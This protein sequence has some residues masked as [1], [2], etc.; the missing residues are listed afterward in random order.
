MNYDLNRFKI[1]QESCYDK[2]LQEIKTGKKISHWMWFIFPQIA[3]LGKTDIAKKYEIANI[4]EAEFYLNDEVLSKRLLQLTRILAYEI[5]NKT[6]EEIF[7]FPDY[8]KFKSSMTL[9]YCVV[10]SK[11][12][13]ENNKDF[14]CFIDTIRKYYAGKLDENT[15]EILRSGTS[16]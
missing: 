7:G 8:L 11:T 5:E 16:F 3:G 1:A 4:E 12:Q 15:I 2:V 14:I 9:F 13:F 6:A 10:K